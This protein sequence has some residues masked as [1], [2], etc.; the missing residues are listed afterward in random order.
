M[1]ILMLTSGDR[2]DDIARCRKLGVSTYLIKPVR[3]AELRLAILSALAAC[4]PLV[5]PV[6][7]TGVETGG[8]LK[9]FVCKYATSIALLMPARF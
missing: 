4:D 7:T 2:G 8:R 6:A 5:E 9:S 3:R 1:V